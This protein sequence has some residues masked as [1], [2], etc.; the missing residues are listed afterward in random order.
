[1]PWGKL[2]RSDRG[3]HR[4]ARQWS[5]PARLMMSRGGYSWDVVTF[6]HWAKVVFL[7]LTGRGSRQR[8]GNNGVRHRLDPEWMRQADDGDFRS[9]RVRSEDCLLHFNGCHSLALREQVAVNRLG[10][11]KNSVTV[12]L[13]GLD[14]EERARWAAE[15][16]VAELGRREQFDSADLSLA[17]RMQVRAT[18][19]SHARTGVRLALLNPGC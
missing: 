11:H 12:V 6:V 3:M 16:L 7:N 10:G 18:P 8:F 19:W 5:A 4:R 13:T 15:M 9:V 1:M 17:W 2:D 14:S